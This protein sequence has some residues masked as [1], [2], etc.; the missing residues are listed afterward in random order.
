MQVVD[1]ELAGAASVLQVL[2]LSP[3]IASGDFAAFHD[4]AIQAKAI[5]AGDTIVLSQLDGSQIVNTLRPFGTPLPAYG[6]TKLQQ[7]TI[8][9]G[10]PVVSDVF[11]GPIGGHAMA[12]VQVPV[13]VDGKAKYTLSIGFLSEGLTELLL[14]QKLPDG[15]VAAIYDRRGTIAA[16]SRAADRFVGKLGAADAVRYVAAAPEGAFAS[17]NLEGLPVQATF[18]RSTFS[19]WAVV[20]AVPASAATAE[21]KLSLWLNAAGAVAALLLGVALA[22]H[23]GRHISRSIT[24]LRLPAL[25]LGSDT[26]V[27][28]PAIDITEVDALRAVLMKAAHLIRRERDAAKEAERR[29]IVSAQAAERANRSKSEFLASISHELRTPLHGILGYAELLRLE[30]GLNPRQSERLKIMMAA[31]AHLLGMINAVLDMSQIEADQM[32]LHPEPITLQE[33]IHDCLN[34]VR[35]AAEKKRLTLVQTPAQPLHLVADPTRLRQV[36]VNLLGNAIKF[37]AA[38]T[39]EVRLRRAAEGER[40]RMEVVDTGPGIQPEHRDKLFRSF[41]RLDGNALRS[42]E[43]AG[44]GLA[45]SARL[46]ILMGGRL[47]HDDNPDG[48]SIFWLELP[49]GNGVA[50]SSAATSGRPDAQRPARALRVLVVDDVSMNRDIASSFLRAAGHHVASAESG[51]EAIEAIENTDFDVVLMDVRMPGMDGLEATR[52]IRSSTGPRRRV[53]I[54]AV[55]AQAFTEQVAEC[56]AA[57]MDGHLGKPFDQ[58]RLLTAVARAADAG[59]AAARSLDLAPTAATAPKIPQPP[60]GDPELPVLDLGAFEQTASHLAPD[61]VSSCLRTIAERGE[62]LV[63]DLREQDALIRNAEALADSA[64]TLA[65]SAGMFGFRRLSIIGRS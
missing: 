12:A 41:E 8:A 61:A 42:V 47:S 14:R 29:M 57:G 44:L 63:R 10:K 55:T 4:R 64:H 62:A 46:V 45:L 5:T 32:E 24:A 20:I 38:G 28:L 31:G 15:G 60:P 22:R 6:D 34:V 16:R 37:T 25:A 50:S 39:I 21:L 52:R 23:V 2:A 18:S 48:G 54:I 7:R 3:L 30:A 19:G 35:P 26:P 58:D 27:V 17:K 53:P 65:G 43:G 11:I 59:P 33:F 51:E 1:G 9:A 56:R 40:I 13:I 49:V 36:L